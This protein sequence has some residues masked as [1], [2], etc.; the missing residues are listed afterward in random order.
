M[1]GRPG[2]RADGAGGASGAA[3]NRFP[4]GGLSRW[5]QTYL[6]PVGERALRPQG[7]RSGK[8]MVVD[9]WLP[10]FV[11]LGQPVPRDLGF[12][13]AVFDPRRQP[14]LVDRH[15]DLFIILDGRAST[16]GSSPRCH[17]QAATTYGSHASSTAR[18]ASC[19]RATGWWFI[20]W[21]WIPIYAALSCNSFIKPIFRIVGASGAA[22]WLTTSNGSLRRLAG[23]DRP[24]V[25]P[26]RRRHEGLRQVPDVGPHGS[27]SSAFAVA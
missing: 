16:Q 14:V 24:G 1:S 4:I 20:L 6:K 7:E 26:G 19:S 21:L 2:S 25:L 17:A 5:R 8:G 12:Y 23:V 22:D 15:H 18:S 9:R 10:L 3:R 11:L 13:Y 27:A